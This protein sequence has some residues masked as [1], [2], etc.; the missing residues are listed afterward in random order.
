MQNTTDETKIRLKIR[1]R[2]ELLRVA[3]TI[4]QETGERVSMSD[5][6][7]WLIDHWTRTKGS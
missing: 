5:A 7:Q 3:G 1:T 6:I 2:D 4:Q